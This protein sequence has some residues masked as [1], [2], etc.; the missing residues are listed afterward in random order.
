MGQVMPHITTQTN[1]ASR[2]TQPRRRPHFLGS[3]LAITSVLGTLTLSQ[4]HAASFDCSKAGTQ[5]EKAICSDPELGRLDEELM[6][7]YKKVAAT[8]R[9]AQRAWLKYRNTCGPDV[10]CLTGMYE[11]RIAVLERAAQP[12][13]PTSSDQ[14]LPVIPQDKCAVITMASKDDAAVLT[15]LRKYWDFEPVA[16]RSNNGYTAAALGIYPKE[17]GVDLART[18]KA[19]DRIP[20]DSYC[21]NTERYIQLVY[22][23]E[24]FS[25]LGDH[26]STPVAAA[27]AVQNVAPVTTNTHDKSAENSQATRPKQAIPP[28]PS[29]NAEANLQPSPNLM[30]NTGNVARSTSVEPNG[31]SPEV[32]DTPVVSVVK[33]TQPPTKSQATLSGQVASVGGEQSTDTGEIDPANKTQ[34]KTGTYLGEWTQGDY[35]KV[36][37]KGLSETSQPPVEFVC[38]PAPTGSRYVMVNI[39]IENTDS[40]SRTLLTEGE[41][42]V[43]HEGKWIEYDQTESC[44]LGQR[45][46]LNFMDDIGPFVMREGKITFIIPNRFQVS[47]MVYLTPRDD[48]K[49]NLK[50]RPN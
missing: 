25:A 1:R 13:T 30:P 24:D 16:I 26:S 23:N 39:Q 21:G 18:L 9:K 17:I 12:Q 20:A 19:V 33:D 49:I 7:A 28:S 11:S 5:V 38:E 48:E 27:V 15:E 8:E 10:Q 43:N 2:S 42:H 44:T 40:E 31:S 22:P 34:P 6:A 50:K 14:V 29:G 45:G 46:F 36:A 47:D 3:L 4:S 35:F 32:T 37:V 41:L